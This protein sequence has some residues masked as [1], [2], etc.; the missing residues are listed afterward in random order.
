MNLT[1]IWC[2]LPSVYE[3]IHVL[4]VRNLLKYLAGNIRRRDQKPR[5]CAALTYVDFENGGWISMFV[6]ERYQG[7][8][9]DVPSKTTECLC[10]TS[11]RTSKF[12][13]Q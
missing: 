6:S 11:L 8:L 12:T 3:M 1:V 2:L 4:Y 10:Q 9:L 13:R 5:I 7:I